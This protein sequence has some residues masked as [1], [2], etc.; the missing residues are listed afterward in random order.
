[1][2]IPEF[3]NHKPVI[4]IGKEAFKDC[5]KFTTVVIPDSVT[6]IGDDAFTGCS[7]I[8]DITLP[9][10][11]L[12]YVSRSNLVN[13]VITSGEKIEASAFKGNKK[14]QSITIP[15]S[16]TE[17]GNYAFQDCSNLWKV[18]IT[19]IAKWCEISF[20]SY[21]SNPLSQGAG[22]YL[23]GELIIDAVIPEGVEAIGVNTFAGYKSLKSIILP[24]SLTT[25]NSFAFQACSEL[26]RIRFGTGISSIQSNAFRQ[27]SK[28]EVVEIA[29]IAKWC[30]VD[31]GEYTANPM[32]FSKGFYLNGDP[33]YELIL[34]DGVTEIS[35]RAFENCTSLKSVIL[36]ASMTTLSV[37]TFSGCSNIEHV[38]IPAELIGYFPKDKLTTV[39]ISN[40]VT[41]IPKNAFKDYSNLTSITL[42]MGVT[43]IGEGAFSGCSSLTSMNIPRN[44]TSIGK[45]AFLG[46][47]D[48]TTLTV[49]EDNT[50][51]SSKNNCIIETESKT[52]VFGCKA[53]IIPADESVTSIGDFAFR[54][55]NGLT[56]VTIPEGV[57][58]IGESAFQSTGLEN[59]VIP[60]SIEEIGAYAFDSC[61]CILSVTL[62]VH[63]WKSVAHYTI[64]TVVLTSGESIESNLFTNYKAISSVTLPD[65]LK[66]IGKDAFYGCSALTE[67][68]LPEGLMTID[69]NAFQNCGGL[70]NVVIPKSVTTIGLGIF[71][72][73]ENLTTLT[74]SE[75]NP[76]YS[77]EGN[78]IIE[79]ESKTLIQGCKETVIPNDGSVTSIDSFSF[80]DLPSLV[81]ITIPKSITKIAKSAIAY[82]SNLT[83]VTI[84]C[85]D[86]II[87][88]NAFENCNGIQEIHINDLA[89]WCSITFDATVAY[90]F[91]N[92]EGL[93][94]PLAVAH[95]LFV[96]DNLIEDSL[97]IPE[98]VESIGKFAFDGLKSIKS[99]TIPDS[100]VK[101]GEGA[102]TSS[103]L[104]EEVHIS[105]LSKWCAI[106]FGVVDASSLTD[107]QNDANIAANPLSKA[108]YLY[109]NGEAIEDL[110][111]PSD[112]TSVHHYAFY[113]GSTFKSI[114][115][116]SNVTTVGT[117]S[118]TC[119]GTTIYCEAKDKP[120]NQYWPASWI[121]FTTSYYSDTN[122]YYRSIAVVWDCKNNQTD[123]TGYQYEFID[124]IKYGLKD[125]EAIV[126]GQPIMI[127]GDITIPETITYDGK[128]YRVTFVSNFAFY[129]CNKITSVIF[130]NS[131]T[132]I[133][134][135]AF[136]NCSNL[137]SVTLSNQLTYIS[138]NTF[139][140]CTSLTSIIIP[141][142]LTQVYTN[143]F[144]DCDA[145]SNVYYMGSASSFSK[146]SF[147]TSSDKSKL[148]SACYYFSETQPIEAGKYWHYENGVPTIWE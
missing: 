46:C 70:I 148:N 134:N 124:G 20:S 123:K 63:A 69:D 29:D 50:K 38:T 113:G 18:N 51:Y 53:S 77:S 25:L 80:Y 133:G 52:L 15:S 72:G 34:P 86:A 108:H 122:R 107:N 112:V 114:T 75:E 41:Y 101:I 104:L 30:A 130:P 141:E 139:S 65:E 68:T 140:N 47:S 44:V 119:P 128:N 6:T 3:H 14:L 99:V 110:V 93:T 43:S 125:D 21:E 131:I 23:D 57:T 64:K 88:K 116:H 24:D 2:I 71:A 35:A 19:D 95:Q 54:G 59:V 49:S 111:I 138:T 121:N 126:P 74:V 37:T 94:N 76:T 61:D 27:C 146:I 16:I 11:A 45:D 73:C 56:S 84:L 13:V 78:C 127:S 90:H 137:L 5:S 8:K 62:P 33:V 85:S 109:L 105:D 106:E 22:L 117:Q 55:C 10:F 115:I 82:C 98:G 103:D 120:A 1:M 67:I 79:T 91:N 135:N 143:V 145:L 42:S 36:P 87:S 26:Q 97:V 136:R 132:D 66:S 9:A 83:S 92:F 39:T 4:E 147:T 31:F 129:N 48:L 32:S 7:G 12:S 58:S 40:G 142:T 60:N 28:L 100:V 102:F 144:S 118:F 96:N 89:D 17:V 81:S